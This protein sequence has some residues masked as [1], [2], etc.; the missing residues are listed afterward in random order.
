[1]ALSWDHSWWRSNMVTFKLFWL[2]LT[3]KKKRKKIFYHNLVLSIHTDTN[4]RTDTTDTW[5]SFKVTLTLSYRWC[6]PS[7]FCSTFFSSLVAQTVKHLPA[8][9]ETGVRFLGQEDP[10]EKEMA[11]QSTLLP[12]KSH[13][14][15][16]LI[17]Y[18]PWGRK[19]S[20]TTERLHFH[21]SLIW[22]AGCDLYTDFIIWKWV[23]T[24]SF[25]NT[26]PGF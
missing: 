26:D 22:S 1:M 3:V 20:D 17:G 6:L 15:R 21:F 8:M 10:L 14:R 25:K 12:G 24:S 16:S 23:V 5:Q 4:I 2:K 9:R 13:G 7:S 11:I 19:E 18:S